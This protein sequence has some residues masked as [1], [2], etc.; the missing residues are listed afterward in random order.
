MCLLCSQWLVKR[1]VE[2]RE[3]MCH[4]VQSFAES[5][6]SKL[7]PLPEEQRILM[8]QDNI[9]RN[10]HAVKVTFSL[11]CEEINVLNIAYRLLI[12]KSRVQ[13]RCLKLK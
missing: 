9:L 3:E 7:C 1:S 10:I 4:F 5:Q 2:T 12:L 8:Q 6:F 13:G 11:L